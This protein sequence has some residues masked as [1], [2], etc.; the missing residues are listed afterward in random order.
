MLIDSIVDIR[1][2]A[3]TPEEVLLLIAIKEY[4]VLVGESGRVKIQAAKCLGQ[5]KSC[6]AR[7]HPSLHPPSV[8]LSARP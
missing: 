3:T 5:Y 6:V 8:L 2:V 7:S 4:G 1:Q